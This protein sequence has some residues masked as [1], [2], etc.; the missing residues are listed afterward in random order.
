[1]LYSPLIKSEIQARTQ[2]FFHLQ[3]FIYA[4]HDILNAA[5]KNQDFCLG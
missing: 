5:I 4:G 3:Q 2:S 1:M